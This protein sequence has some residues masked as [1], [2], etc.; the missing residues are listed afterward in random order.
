MWMMPETISSSPT[1]EYLCLTV[2]LQPEKG[3]NLEAPGVDDASTHVVL[4]VRVNV[5]QELPQQ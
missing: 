4:G 5:L 2:W 3:A 1:T